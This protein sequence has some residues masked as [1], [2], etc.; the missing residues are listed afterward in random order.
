MCSSARPHR[1]RTLRTPAGNPVERQPKL[2]LTQQQQ[3]SAAAAAAAAL[4]RSRAGC[5]ARPPAV[6]APR[7]CGRRVPAGGQGVRG[8]VCRGGAAGVRCAG[9]DLDLLRGEHPHLGAV[10]FSTPLPAPCPTMLQ[11]LVSS[12]TARLSATPATPACEAS[13]PP[14]DELVRG[15]AFHT[16]GRFEWVG[17][18]CQ[19]FIHSATP[20]GPA[21]VFIS[22]HLRLAWVA[23][24]TTNV[25]VGAAP[26]R[27]SR[28][29]AAASRRPDTSLGRC[30]CRCQLPH[31]PLD[32]ARPAFHLL[33]SAVCRPP[34]TCGLVGCRRAPGRPCCR[35]PRISVLVAGVMQF[36]RPAWSRQAG[37]T[38]G[39]LQAC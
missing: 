32:R 20:A 1:P 21:G 8:L 2:K 22:A 17:S 28:Y 30:C 19:P 11:Q 39:L 12:A 5:K 34:S 15:D 13:M 3:L 18:A 29:A 4:A 25:A 35:A 38:W 6:P 24:P 37:W 31:L 9:T 27:H 26:G 10:S 36:P 23:L 7:P 33:R 14:L 16:S